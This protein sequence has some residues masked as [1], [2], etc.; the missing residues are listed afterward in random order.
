MQNEL[1]LALR[2]QKRSE[3]E[4][5]AV[6]SMIEPS[7]STHCGG[8][9]GTDVEESEETYLILHDVVRCKAMLI[10]VERDAA[11]Q[12]QSRNSYLTNAATNCD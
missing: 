5:W 3:K 7:A 10:R 8:K 12:K 6:A 9:H 4:L 11:T 1:P 2:P